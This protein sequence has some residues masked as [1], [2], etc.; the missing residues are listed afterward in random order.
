MS[1]PKVWSKFTGSNGA[2][3]V[4]ATAPS[5]RINEAV[6]LH[7]K[8]YLSE[9]PLSKA[10]DI[11]NNK[12]ALE[13]YKSLLVDG[14]NT[15]NFALVAAV[16]NGGVGEI[17]GVS[18]S[19]IIASDKPFEDMPA[20]KTKEIERLYAITGAMHV[21]DILSTY[22]VDKYLDS[23]G[24][25]IHPNYKNLGI[26]LELLKA[27]KL[28]AK[29]QSIPLSVGWMMSDA[30]QALAQQDG[31][32]VHKELNYPEFGQ[33]HGLNFDNSPSTIKYVVSKV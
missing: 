12:D 21:P 24:I 10:L 7:I 11:A 14:A 5:D 20:P 23:F 28:L 8:Q 4:I 9:D 2:K 13:E 29:E 32:S 6:D 26:E 30:L 1:A 3:L 16:D 33:Q 25:A 27:R 15:T 18:F 17:V 19:Y 31:Y 22:K